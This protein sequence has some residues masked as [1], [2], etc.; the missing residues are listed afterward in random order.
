MLTPNV[1]RQLPKVELHC[2]LEG[3]I[4][5]STLVALADRHGV[6]LPSWDPAEL[7]G[8]ADLA[9]FL[10]VYE[11]ACDVLRRPDDFARVTYESLEDAAR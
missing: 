11:I 9:G 8:Y 5:P 10:T 7:Y 3:S 2:H 6:P 1:L 4:R